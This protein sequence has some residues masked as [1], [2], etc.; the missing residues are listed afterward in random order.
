MEARIC[1]GQAV[2]F[3][4]PRRTSVGLQGA[5]PSSCCASADFEPYER[6]SHALRR[7]CRHVVLKCTLLAFLLISCLSAG[8]ILGILYPP[9]ALE[10]RSPAS[11]GWSQVRRRLSASGGDEGSNGEDNAS[12]SKKASVEKAND[13]EGEAG[14]RNGGDSGAEVTNDAA[15]AAAGTSSTELPPPESPTAP[16]HDFDVEK[17]AEKVAIT[18]TPLPSSAVHTAG[19]GMDN[20]SGGKGSSARKQRRRKRRSDLVNGPDPHTYRKELCSMLRTDATLQVWFALVVLYVAEWPTYARHGNG[21]DAYLKYLRDLAQKF[22]VPRHAA[23][24]VQML[25]AEELSCGTPSFFLGGLETVAKDIH[26][27]HDLINVLRKYREEQ[28]F[29][30][31]IDYTQVT[32]LPADVSISGFPMILRT[33]FEGFAFC[34]SRNLYIRPEK[35]GD[36]KSSRRTEGTGALTMSDFYNTYVR[37]Y[38][39][40]QFQYWLLLMMASVMKRVVSGRPHAGFMV[41]KFKSAQALG[42]NRG[43]GMHELDKAAIDSLQRQ[44]AASVEG[45]LDRSLQR[46]QNFQVVQGPLFSTTSA[47][48]PTLSVTGYLERTQAGSFI[49]HGIFGMDMDLDTLEELK[50]R[51]EPGNLLVD[52]SLVDPWSSRPASEWPDPLQRDVLALTAY[53]ATQ[54]LCAELQ[55]DPSLGNLGHVEVVYSGFADVYDSAASTQQSKAKFDPDVQVLLLRD[56]QKFVEDGLEEGSKEKITNLVAQEPLQWGQERVIDAERIQ[57]KGVARLLRGGQLYRKNAFGTGL[58]PT[59]RRNAEDLLKPNV[60][61][62]HIVIQ[63]LGDLTPDTLGFDMTASEMASRLVRRCRG[64]YDP[65]LLK[66]V[67]PFVKEMQV[68]NERMCVGDMPKWVVLV[69][70]LGVA[71]F[72]IILITLLL[73]HDKIK[74]PWWIMCI[75]SSRAPWEESSPVAS[76]MSNAFPPEVFEK[77]SNSTRE[78]I[79]FA[80]PLKEMTSSLS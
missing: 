57:W 39:H 59:L 10:R 16:L 41:L 29:A 2:S 62:I 31:L 32:K 25:F 55:W 46:F 22:E 58:P 73:Y 37:Q 7:K 49:D 43:R 68:K 12:V 56:N 11:A 80:P 21:G 17:D 69:S 35:K 42:M 51:M 74:L 54:L 19:D 70:T 26:R 48:R 27:H 6:S 44:V 40:N 66:S 50:E 14:Q 64:I 52:V 8:Y 20:T 24:Q 77:Q 9:A 38:Q 1:D 75:C 30:D 79:A 61:L 33:A 28:D 47:M 78:I 60:V 34:F 45:K 15:A 3:V 13:N 76:S 36:D 4:R 65:V 23:V 71:L 53:T 5:R 72:F 67:T 63:G 18:G